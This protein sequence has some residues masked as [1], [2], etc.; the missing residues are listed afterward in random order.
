[1]IWKRTRK[2]NHLVPC[3]IQL[4]LSLQG[5]GWLKKGRMSGPKRDVC[6]IYD[7]KKN[8]KICFFFHSKVTGFAPELF[9]EIKE[10]DI[11]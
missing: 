7:K 1:M 6:F 3:G 10:K 8:M 9:N 11:F 5:S 2:E 4:Y